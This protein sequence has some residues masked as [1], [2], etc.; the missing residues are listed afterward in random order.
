MIGTERLRA[1]YLE[2][3]PHRNDYDALG[4]LWAWIEASPEGQTA[5]EANLQAIARR[6]ET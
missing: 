2:A 5:I 1:L 4:F 6:N 3:Y